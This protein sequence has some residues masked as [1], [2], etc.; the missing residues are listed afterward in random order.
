MNKNMCQQFKSVRTY[1]P[2]ELKNGNY[3]F[4]S[5]GQ[6]FNKY[7][8][9]NRCDSNLEQINSACLYLFN[10]FF[11]NSFSF[12]NNAN[13]NI[14]VVDYIIIWLSYILS[15][16]ENGINKLDDFYTNHIKTNTHYKTKIDDVSGYKCFMEIID[17]KKDLLNMDIDNNNNIISNF[18]K[19][20]KSLCE[21]YSEFGESTSNCE[22]SDYNNLKNK[23]KDSNF[24]TFPEIST[25]Q[26]AIKGPEQISENKS[27]TNS[28]Q[29][30][31]QKSDVTSSSSIVSKLIPVL[32]IFGA[33]PIFLGI[34]YKV[35]NKELKNYFHYIYPNYS[36]FGFRK[37]PQKQHLREMLKK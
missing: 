16:K 24:S 21:M 1:F 34:S 29:K 30:F 20:F 19:A 37:R 6:H 8:T 31:E 7:C 14:D 2:D 35:N 18:Y 5:N 9:N 13:N 10:A 22:N 36:L 4:L 26:I 33:I 15:L 17:T 32:S 25:P 3:D 28:E 11:V 27:E 12:K 23:C